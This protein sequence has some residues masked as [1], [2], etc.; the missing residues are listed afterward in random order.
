MFDASL[1]RQHKVVM[2]L[3]Q[4]SV[5]EFGEPPDWRRDLIGSRK[6]SYYY[7]KQEGRCPLCGQR[8]FFGG[9]WIEAT[10]PRGRRGVWHQVCVE[11]WRFWIAPQQ[12]SEWLAAQQQFV[13]PE[14]GASL[15]KVRTT[16][17]RY[18]LKTMQECIAPVDVDHRRPLW[19]VWCELEAGDHSWPRVLD[20]WGAPNLAAITP[21][22]HKA[23][24]KREAAERARMKRDAGR[25]LECLPS[26]L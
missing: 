24:S 12:S 8:S 3:L 9:A 11:V 1:A 13:C 25:L 5:L 14:S 17:D 16:V 26:T 18:G 2:G 21:E 4:R 10:G 7:G 23:K 15:I 6:P 22:A 20:F 19:R